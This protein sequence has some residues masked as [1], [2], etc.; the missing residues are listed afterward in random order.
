MAGSRHDSRP[1]PSHDRAGL[2]RLSPSLLL[3]L[4]LVLS[5]LR[6]V[7]SHC[8]STLTRSSPSALPLC[9]SSV[10]S[11]TASVRLIS[12]SIS[13][14]ITIIITVAVVSSSSSSSSLSFCVVRGPEVDLLR[15]PTATSPEAPSQT[16]STF[17]ELS[18]RRLSFRNFNLSSTST[19]RST[20]SP[21]AASSS[22][23]VLD[24]V[25]LP[26]QRPPSSRSRL[27]LA[28]LPPGARLTASL[29]VLALAAGLFSAAHCVAST[30]ILLRPPLSL[31]LYACSWAA[32]NPPL[33]V[34]LRLLLSCCRLGW[35]SRL[36]SPAAYTPLK[37]D[38]RPFALP[39]IP[40]LP[41]PSLFLRVLSPSTVY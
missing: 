10:F 3:L 14:S 23:P 4:L 6:S 5:T 9:L 1:R 18:L 15:P 38:G 36:E 8:T 41:K 37:E 33:P 13:I 29:G 40:P 25:S 30:C 16:R 39:D 11:Q 17:L 31:S 24:A 28:V 34:V 32:E 22:R 21:A 2:M 26:A 20:T 12:I 27:L 19:Q 35:L 7:L